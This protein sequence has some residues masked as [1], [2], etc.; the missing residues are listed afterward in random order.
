MVGFSQRKLLARST[1]N[2]TVTTCTYYIFVFRSAK[3]C[4]GQLKTLVTTCTYYIFVTIL[5]TS[6]MGRLQNG[7]SDLRSLPTPEEG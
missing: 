7:V 5:Q 3:H 1:E 6:V 2:S 4:Q